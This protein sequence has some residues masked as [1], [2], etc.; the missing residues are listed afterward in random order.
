MKLH[1]LT[2]EELTQSKHR[3]ILEQLDNIRYLWVTYFTSIISYLSYNSLISKDDPLKGINKDLQ[4]EWDIY[5]KSADA[6][7]IDTVKDTL[8]EKLIQNRY[9]NWNEEIK[10]F[11]EDFIPKIHDLHLR[12]VG[13]C[14]PNMSKWES[15][16]QRLVFSKLNENFEQ[17]D[18]T[19]PNIFLYTGIGFILFALIVCKIDYSMTGTSLGASI[20]MFTLYTLQIFK[21][22]S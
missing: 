18:S 6:N 7:S 15:T 13:D 4:N 9:L 20:V 21:K 19:S 1:L 12:I 5:I 11:H 17:R 8:K 3:E 2:E 14:E 22:L 10:K 16:Y